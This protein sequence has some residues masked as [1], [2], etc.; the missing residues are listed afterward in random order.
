MKKQ[1]R[2]WACEGQGTG[3]QEGQ[4]DSSCDNKSHAGTAGLG[5]RRQY[6]NT[7]RGKGQVSPGSADTWDRRLLIRFCVCEHTI[8]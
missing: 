2:H 5:W 7:A 6:G 4:Q 1:E 3:R 8:K